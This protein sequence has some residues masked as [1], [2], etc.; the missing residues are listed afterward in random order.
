MSW[1]GSYWDEKWESMRDEEEANFPR[2]RGRGWVF[3]VGCEE[4]EEKGGGRGSGPTMDSRGSESDCCCWESSVLI[5]VWS[6]SFRRVNRLSSVDPLS[7]VFGKALAS[8]EYGDVD[9]FRRPLRL[10]L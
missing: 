8:G 5:W 4:E 2:P 7:P 3:W 10:R 1:E 9:L 6:V